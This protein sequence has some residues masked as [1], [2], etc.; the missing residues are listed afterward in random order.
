MAEIIYRTC[1][2][3]SG[4]GIIT[5]IINESGDTENVECSVCSGSGKLKLGEFDLADI[6][7]KLNDI[8]DKVNDCWNKLSD[9]WEKLNE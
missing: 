6:Q 1:Y 8:Q 3:C 9:I 2:S 4:D 5:L 7:E